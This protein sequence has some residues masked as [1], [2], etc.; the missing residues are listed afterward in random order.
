VTE[1]SDP[2][3]D[4]ADRLR[5]LGIERGVVPQYRLKT[6]TFGLEEGLAP[7]KQQS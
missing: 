4:L 2:R 7:D 1:Q 6:P 5:L 3:G